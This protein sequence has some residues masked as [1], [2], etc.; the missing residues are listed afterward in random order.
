M[1]NWTSITIAS[2]LFPASLANTLIRRKEKQ[3]P[4]GRLVQTER[5][6]FHVIEKGSGPITVLMDAGLSG[7]SLHWHRV[8]EI[9]SRHAHTI[10]FDRK[11]YGWSD[12]RTHGDGLN[13]V[14]DIEALLAAMDVTSPLILVGHSYGGLNVRLF[15]SENRKKV[16]GIVFV[17]AVG[18]ERYLTEHFDAS[19]K[20]EWKKSLQM[21]KV[22]YYTAYTGI[23]RLLGM[24][25]GG[26]YLF[27]EL[28]SYHRFVGYSPHAYE[29]VFKELR[30]SE[31]TAKQV[32]NSL[33][34]DRSLPITVIQ[35]GNESEE[36]IRYQQT[37]K[38]LTD[39]VTDIPTNHGHNIHMENP[40]LVA[41]AVMK[42]V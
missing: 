18:E 23:P 27:P 8:Q 22:G 13:T 11:G 42:H 38:C 33:P 25:V 40:D 26:K 31:M 21:M 36:W 4:P 2:L 12:R 9:V 37:L 32:V 19:R 28:K 17:D 3:P 20:N 41:D 14:K 16:K 1:K 15:A 10:S 35:S 24:K 30:D 39:H 34:L 6:T 7:Q 29:A 5:G